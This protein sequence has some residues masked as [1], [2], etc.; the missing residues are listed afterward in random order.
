MKIVKLILTAVVVVACVLVVKHFK[1]ASY[2]AHF[3]PAPIRAGVRIKG[4]LDAKIRITEF[5]DFQCPACGKVVPV[6]DEL[7]KKYNGKLSLEHKHFPLP[8][9]KNAKKASIFAECASDQGKFWPYHDVLFKSQT[10]WI[11]LD[12]PSQYFEDLG[13]QLGL[14]SDKLKACVA[15]E[16]AEKRIGSDRIDGEILGVKATPTFV[17]EGKLFVGGDNLKTELETRLGK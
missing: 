11:S 6:V 8:M 17:I 1:T 3:K 5:T 15:G 4:T 16:A 2:K 9:H 10:S 12:D 14:N 7:L 13:M